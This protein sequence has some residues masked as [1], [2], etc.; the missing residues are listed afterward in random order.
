[1]RKYKYLC[2][3]INQKT[4]IFYVDN[5]NWNLVKLGCVLF[6]KDFSLAASKTGKN[7]ASPQIKVIP[8]IR[9][10]STV[11]QL[12]HQSEL[13]FAKKFFT[14][15]LE[16]NVSY[17]C[18]GSKA[19]RSF[20]TAL[21]L[22]AIGIKVPKPSFAL[23][24]RDGPFKK[25]S[26]YLTPQFDGPSLKSFIR[27]NIE[28]SKESVTKTLLNFSSDLGVLYRNRFVQGDPNLGNFLVDPKNNQI[29]FIDI[30]SFERL[31]ASAAKEEILRNLANINGNIF[32]IL[33]ENHLGYLYSSDRLRFFLK[34]FREAYGG[35]VDLSEAFTRLSLAT[36]RY[37]I[38][39]GKG[40]LL[41]EAG[42]CFLTQFLSCQ[43]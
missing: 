9:H 31:S 15:S 4:K 5:P 18:K 29:T 13:Y 8:T 30:D 36:V 41:N 21:D 42:D 25:E 37:L 16:Q 38:R 7:V 26:I 10:F 32:R 14:S 22:M 40:N 12:E 2:N 33:A 20:E 6:N 19:I 43:E 17:L 39:R 27:D 3:K 11:Y 1:M 24:H 28:H 35:S 23:V 34:N